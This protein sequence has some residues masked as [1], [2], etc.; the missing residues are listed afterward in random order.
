MLN[1]GQEVDE[2]AGKH[3]REQHSDGGQYQ[4]RPHHRAD[5]FQFGFQTASEQDYAQCYD[6]Q[7]LRNVIIVENQSKSVASEQHSHQQENEE[8]W[9]AVFVSCLRNQYGSEDQYGTYEKNVL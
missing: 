6:T 8:G 1:S 3:Y 4:T 2:C 9:Y 7:E 5:V